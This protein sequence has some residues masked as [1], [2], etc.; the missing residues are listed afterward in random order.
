MAGSRRKRALRQY[1][2][3]I[4]IR[5]NQID[6]LKTLFAGIHHTAARIFSEGWQNGQAQ[7]WVSRGS[8]PELCGAVGVVFRD[9]YVVCFANFDG[10]LLTEEI[11][12]S[13]DDLLVDL[14]SQRGERPLFYNV[15]GDM[16]PVIALL[17][18]RCF[19]EDTFGYELKCCDAPGS[20]TEG[21]GLTIRGFEPQHFDTYVRLLDGAFNPL[22][23][24]TGHHGDPFSREGETFRKRLR[25]SSDWGDFAS[26]WVADQ[27]VGLYTLSDDVIDILAVHP[28]FQNLGYGTAM[29]EHALRRILCEGGF[30]A[31]YLFVV[32]AN[33]EARRLYLRL[34][35]EVSGFYSENTYVGINC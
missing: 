29:T 1:S 33:E 16:E 20:P 26:F 24:R 14:I 8:T 30:P 22:M 3:L 11:I 19:R 7:A 25:N 31:A 35:F 21:A 34:G 15:R 5:E 17:R 18:Q 12:Q 23:A 2:A 27:L 10:E 13:L 9:D 4:P 32:A 28:Q 6:R